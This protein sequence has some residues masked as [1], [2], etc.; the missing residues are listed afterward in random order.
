MIINTK[1]DI[2]NWVNDCM[3]N[4][5]TPAQLNDAAFRISAYAHMIGLTYGQDWSTLLEKLTIENLENMAGINE[6]TS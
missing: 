4:D 2:I 6:R 3:Q 1:T 5:V